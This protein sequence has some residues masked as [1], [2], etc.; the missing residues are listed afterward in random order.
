VIGRNEGDKIKKEE[1]SLVQNGELAL[2]GRVIEGKTVSNNKLTIM[3]S[4]TQKLISLS[5]LRLKDINGIRVF[6]GIN[7]VI[8]RL[9]LIEVFLHYR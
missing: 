7:Q 2:A 4:Q 1:E 5:V 8:D 3:W 9:K 6:E